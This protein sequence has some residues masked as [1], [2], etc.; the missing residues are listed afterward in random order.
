M[1][2][3][4]NLR[5]GSWNRMLNLVCMCVV[6]IKRTPF[7]VFPFAVFLKLKGTREI[8]F[9]LGLAC[10]RK[11]FYKVGT[12]HCYD[13]PIIPFISGFNAI[14]FRY[15]RI[16][17]LS[18]SYE[19]TMLPDKGFTCTFLIPDGRGKG[20]DFLKFLYTYDHESLFRAGT[21]TRICPLAW[22]R[23]L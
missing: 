11:P 7:M 10:K 19:I 23:I 1:T 5:A 17:M 13:P 15:S 21:S 2:K 3:R 18:G 14:F 9:F 20:R 8:Q 22:N 4:L 12:F 6:C 16:F